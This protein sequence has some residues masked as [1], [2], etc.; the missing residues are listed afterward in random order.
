MRCPYCKDNRDKVIDS[1]STDGGTAI[2]RR[3]ECLACGKRYSSKE[4]LEP[5]GRHMVLKK[6]GTRMPFDRDKIRAG[7]VTASYKRPVSEEQIQELLDS[8]EEEVF[9]EFNREVASQ[10]IGECVIRR[11]RALDKVAYVRFA[12][13][14]RE[15]NDPDQFV[16]EVHDV[17]AR[18]EHESPGQKTLFD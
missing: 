9:R 12:S 1:R 11:L 15:F 16:E 13:V 6:D 3:R 4:R 17:Q 10:V 18:A 14:Y 8:V 5:S 2:R 7:V